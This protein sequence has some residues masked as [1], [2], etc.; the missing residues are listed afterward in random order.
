MG[1]VKKTF[2]SFYTIYIMKLAFI[3]IA[4]FAVGRKAKAMFGGGMMMGGIEELDAQD[5]YGDAQHAHVVATYQHKMFNPEC[6]YTIDAIKKY[7]S[8]VV[9]GSLYRV[10]YTIRSRNCQSK[11]CKAELIDQPWVNDFSKQLQGVKCI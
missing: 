1:L 11:Y 9:A 5:G 6:Y 10:E 8:Q 3:I 7:S 2:S 4:L